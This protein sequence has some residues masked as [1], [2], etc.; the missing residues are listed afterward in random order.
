[1]SI[2]T[3]WHLSWYGARTQNSCCKHRSHSPELQF[4]RRTVLFIAKSTTA[5]S[6]I[7]V[8]DKTAFLINSSLI[9]C[10]F[11]GNNAVFKAKVSGN[12]SPNVTWAREGSKQLTEAAKTF[13][14]DVNKH[15]VLKVRD[16][17][18][19]FISDFRICSGCTQENYW[20]GVYYVKPWQ[21]HLRQWYFKN[22]EGVKDAVH[23]VMYNDAVMKFCVLKNV[24]MSL[25]NS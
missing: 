20:F 16:R 2:R 22:S 18:T 15:Y 10:H 24:S 17:S 14:D 1:M 8:H 12:P 11:T 23:E 21:W 13:Y 19:W 7:S 3:Q 9:I 25:I 4:L 6:C 5:K